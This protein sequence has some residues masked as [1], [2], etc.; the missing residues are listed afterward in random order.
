MRNRTPSAVLCLT[1][2]ALTA[3]APSR[4]SHA[5]DARVELVP[6]ASAVAFRAY[7]MGLLPLDGE[8]TRFHG[9]IAYDPDDHAACQVELRVEVASLAMSGDAPRD[10]ILGPDF[11]DA[12]RFPA[13]TYDGACGTDGLDGRL[14]MH[15]VTRPFALT[16]D[17]TPDS[18][19]AVGRLRRADWG[20]TAMPILGGS[21]VRIAVSVRLAEPPHAGP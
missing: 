16:L 17:W 19:V 15:G 20:M 2:A 4:P 10:D 21:T 14:A 13:L 6:G 12:A 3:A 8:F 5:A 1:V 9:W 18:V 7:G 11:L